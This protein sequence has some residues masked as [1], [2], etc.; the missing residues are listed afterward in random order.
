MSMSLKAK[1]K[2]SRGSKRS[3]IDP[4]DLTSSTSILV[5]TSTA[6]TSS[7]FHVALQ[8]HLRKL[9]A[10]EEFAFLAAYKTL[11]PAGLLPS[12]RTYDDKNRSGSTFRRCLPKISKCFSVLEELMRS[13]SIGIQSN[14]EISAIVVGAAPQCG[15]LLT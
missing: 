2:T 14:P 1:L 12:V 5:H 11:T 7:A 3:G 9:K 6:N 4:D 15:F 10:D 8:K 13:V